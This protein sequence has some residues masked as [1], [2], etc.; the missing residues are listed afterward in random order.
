MTDNIPLDEQGRSFH[1]KAYI[2]AGQLKDASDLIY[3][4][5]NR[6][7]APS[8]K[9]YSHLI[10]RLFLNTT[11]TPST[12]A[13]AW[14]MFA[15]MRYVAR[16]TPD[17]YFY[18]IMI[19]ACADAP[20][21]QAERA[22]DLFTEM[23]IDNRIEPTRDAYNWTILA[24]A[25][26]SKDFA[27]DAFRLAQ[28]MF[29]S[30]RTGAV[31]MRPDL[32]TFC[33]LLESAKRTGDLKR[34][35]WILA[36]LI[37]AYQRGD[38]SLRP[39]E[40]VMAHVFQMYTSYRPPFNR[41][42]VRR[43][44]E[45]NSEDAVA[46]TREISYTKGTRIHPDATM[47]L[48]QSHAETISEA[49]MFYNRMRDD[50]FRAKS[51]EPASRPGLPIFSHVI[52]TPDLLNSYLSVYFAHA[53]LASARE[54]YDAVF[55]EFD[56]RRTPRTYLLALQRCGISRTDHDRRDAL[57]FA[58]SVWENWRI[59]EDSQLA[60]PERSA[61]TPKISPRTIEKLWS[62]MIRVLTLCVHLSS[63]CSGPR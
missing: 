41:D 33:A 15:H 39:D 23:R 30:S 9:T 18:A 3:T 27:H 42:V 6:N 63:L 40:E 4:Y 13:L 36:E 31:Q 34:T 24:C 20:I 61:T 62:S 52:P 8:M 17:A 7:L 58:R 25:R 45:P 1:V 54:T 53:S 43:T 46:E 22:L 29:D 16:P 28:E 35:R 32:N 44:Q 47:D 57:P 19:R 38:E 26:A 50:I 11:A 14:D 5:E 48:P 56:T 60:E 59:M 21:P 49:T 37:N 2:R 51:T 55:A 12:R 10:S